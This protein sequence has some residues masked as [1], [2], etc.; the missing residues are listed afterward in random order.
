VLHP[1]KNNCAGEYAFHWISS[2]LTKNSDFSDNGHFARAFSKKKG[3]ETGDISN[4][5]RVRL[6]TTLICAEGP[7]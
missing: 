1:V 6:E 2:E 3:K 4:E 5:G 7:E